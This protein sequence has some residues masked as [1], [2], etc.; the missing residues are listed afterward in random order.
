M[1][2]M[3]TKDKRTVRNAEKRPPPPWGT[4]CVTV[5]LWLK[6]IMNSV[7]QSVWWKGLAQLPFFLSTLGECQKE[8]GAVLLQE[9]IS[10]FFLMLEGS[11]TR[12]PPRGLLTDTT[13]GGLTIL[14]YKIIFYFSLT[15]SHILLRV[16]LYSQT[17][18]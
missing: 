10:S 13:A 16:M 11:Y 7:S 4:C 12:Q 8:F 1:E 14:F 17:F 15:I 6:S 9:G 18:L 2:K 5:L 3:A